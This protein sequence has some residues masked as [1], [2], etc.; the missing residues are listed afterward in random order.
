MIG[1]I[2]MPEQE[3][4]KFLGQRL[5]PLLQGVALPGQGDFRTSR[6]A[7]LGNAPGDRTV[8]GDP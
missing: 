8:V 2:A 1:D 5:D 3:A 7:R 6:V 4:V